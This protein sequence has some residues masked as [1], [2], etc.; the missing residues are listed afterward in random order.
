MKSTRLRQLSLAFCLLVSLFVSSV[1]ACACSHHPENV[2][3]VKAESSSCHQHSE[4]ETE[5]DVV[6]AEQQQDII[7]DENAQS[8]VPID[9]CCCIQAF[10]RIVAKSETIKIEKQALSILPFSTIEPHFVLQIVTVESDFITPFYLTDSFYNL[11]P[12]RAPPI[13]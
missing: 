4:K 8:I 3:T 11:T 13:L 5:R 6:K 1:S 12:G 2:E 10:P 9:E 7:S